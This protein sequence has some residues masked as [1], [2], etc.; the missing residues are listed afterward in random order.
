MRVTDPVWRQFLT[1][2]RYG[3]VKQEDLIMLRSLIITNPACPDT[4]FGEEPWSEAALVT[5]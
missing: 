4:N 3:E 2:L 1:N 5:P